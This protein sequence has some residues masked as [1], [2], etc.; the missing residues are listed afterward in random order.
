MTKTITRRTALAG[1]SA[2][3]FAPALASTA[4]A[5][6]AVTIVHGFTP[7]GNVDLTARLM[8]D[9][10]G[11]RLGQKIV[12]EPKPGAGGSTAAA[13]VARATPDGTTLF[14]AAG[15]HAVSA[16]VYNKLPFRSLEDFSWISMLTDFPFVFVTYPDHPAKNLA[17]FIRMAKTQEA[18]LLCA[19][20][21]N[22]TGMHLAL[23]LF[24]ATA[25]IKIQHVPYRG[26]PQAA[27]DLLGKRVDAVMD[28]LT[29]VAEMVRDGRLRAFGTTGPSRFFALPDAPTFAEA[30]VPNY[31]VTSWLGLAGPA[32]LPAPLLQKLN[33]EVVAI[34][35][36][37]GTI[38]RLKKI[39]GEPRPMTAEAYRARVASDIAKWTKVVADAGIP[40][41]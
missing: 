15:G 2:L 23:E 28:N 35:A 30:G 38:E 3:G 40:R 1:L 18:K 33:A 4:R 24:A 12:V 10:L 41:V 9:R 17:E 26:S 36:E 34:L 39:G 27:T 7:G 14:L 19:T 31:A 6:G 22:G 21:G 25:G 13:Y 8:A 37:P 32:G 16:A 20:A 11:A 5:E 29:V